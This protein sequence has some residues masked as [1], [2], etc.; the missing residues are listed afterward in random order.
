MQDGLEALEHS[1]GAQ[2]LRRARALGVLAERVRAVLPADLAAH[3]EVVGFEAG[4]LRLLVSSSVRATQL[5][6]HQRDLVETLGSIGG[7]PI[8]AVDCI[9]RSRRPA[10]ADSGLSR[11]PLGVS[12]GAAVHIEAAAREEDD[13]DLRAALLRL[14]S[15]RR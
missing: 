10:E 15:R 4:H 8:L 2:V 11:R 12:P 3:C 6:Y 5:R 7:R 1:A 9:V 14:A 13:P